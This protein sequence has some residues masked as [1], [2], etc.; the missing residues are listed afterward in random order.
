[1]TTARTDA[2]D[3]RWRLVRESGLR[4]VT[5]ASPTIFV[6]LLV[7]GVVDTASHLDDGSATWRL[8]SSLVPA[9]LCG[10]LA[11]LLRAVDVPAEFSGL[12]FVLVSLAVGASLWFTYLKTGFDTDLSYL[13]I[14]IVFVGSIAISMGEF[15]AVV[16]SLSAGTL[17]SVV[18]L[19]SSGQG[20]AHAD[21][22]LMVVLVALS[23][24]TS[25]HLARR[26]SLS[27]M[28]SLQLILE[29]QVAEDVLTGLTT[30]RG[31]S[32]A[33]PLLRAQAQRLNLPMFALFVDVDGLKAVNDLAGHDAG[34]LV[35]GASG[36]AVR[37]HCRASD[38][39]VRWGG[40]EFVVV[41]LG[42]GPILERFEQTV[43]DELRTNNP[44]PETW[45]AWVSIGSVT[46]PAVDLDLAALITAADAEMYR[47][48]SARR[49]LSATDGQVPTASVN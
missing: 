5:W 15:V 46:R 42:E 34:D 27:H 28:A 1:M 35:I 38:L 31:L 6:L 2:E 47:R 14:L 49:S 39:V 44:A 10:A 11:G 3:A 48:R 16:L 19:Q 40:D 7:F 30:R 37:K 36:A 25:I 23:A 21:R 20:E 32:S 41:G 45:D 24:S 18:W 26:R 17:A 29:Q 8:L 4:E 22:W 13:M 9:L 12:L 33:F 43:A